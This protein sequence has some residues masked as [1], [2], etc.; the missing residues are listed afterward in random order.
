MDSK[1]VK[2]A[3]PNDLSAY[4]LDDYDN[5]VSRGAAMGAFSNIKGLS[6]YRDNNDDP[7]I[8]LK[9]VRAR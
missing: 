4:N 9:D 8:T 5:E 7:Y 3:D 2:V 6:F 1:P